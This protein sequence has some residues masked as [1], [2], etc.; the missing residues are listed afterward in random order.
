M[1]S[2]DKAQ[3]IKILSRHLDPADI[4]KNRDGV[5]Y[6]KF[7]QELELLSYC[8]LGNH[9]HLLFYLKEDHTVLQAYM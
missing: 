7:N 4:S 6:R 8:L 9:F 3:F 5:L 1:D 2:R